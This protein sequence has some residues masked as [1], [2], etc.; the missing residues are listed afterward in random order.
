MY[1]L[2]KRFCVAALMGVVA[3]CMVACQPK[4]EEIAFKQYSY[5]ENPYENS[6]T[7][8]GVDISV[9]LT[10]PEQLEQHPELMKMYDT[11]MGQLI[12]AK[13]FSKNPDSA[14][15]Q[16]CAEV[17]T[18]FKQSKGEVAEEDL[19]EIFIE[20][21]RWE[22]NVELSPNLVSDEIVC[23]VLDYWTYTGGIHGNGCRSYLVFD[24]LTG[25]RLSESEIFNLT[26]GN[27]EIITNM[28]RDVYHQN[29]YT[30]SDGYWSDETVEMNGNFTITEEGIKY[31]YNSY[32]IACYA[33]GPSE[34]FL[35]KEQLKPYLNKKSSVYR[36]WF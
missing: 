12:S 23:F 26:D 31:Y 29:G 4:V 6:D 20:M 27:K 10:L 2:K 32:E 21:F 17:R 28:L 7:A 18:D 5:S 11:L 9:K 33:N 24:R 36:F 3:F 34:F 22:T 1:Y 14:I 19:D 25:D 35:S 15:A 8:M 16:Y 30:E 13:D